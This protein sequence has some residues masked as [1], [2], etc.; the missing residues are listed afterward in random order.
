MV[1]ESVNDTPITMHN[2][3][4][5]DENVEELN[6]L[7]QRYERAVVSILALIAECNSYQ[8]FAMA[9]KSQTRNIEL[10]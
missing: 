1:M 2:P 10:K 5:A 4:K 7:T 3:S 6:S 8:T 9:K